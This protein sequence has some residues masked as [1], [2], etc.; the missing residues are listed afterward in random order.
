VEAL[1][2]KA[3]ILLLSL[4]LAACAGQGMQPKATST[5]TG[6][7]SGVVHKYD[8][9]GGIGPLLSISIC[10]GD[11]PPWF[12]GRTLSHFYVGVRE[13]DAIANG[14]STPIIAL[15]SPYVV[16]LLAYQD[17]NMA[18]LGS[19]SIAAANYS[20]L[21]FVFDTASA[22]AIF[23]DGTT[24]PVTF[25]TNNGGGNGAGASTTTATDPNIAGAVDVT[26]PASVGSSDTYGIDFNALE[27]M[28][29]VNNN[30]MKIRAAM[31]ASS[32]TQSGKITGTI[33]NQ[34]GSPVQNVVVAAVGSNG[35]IVNTALTGPYGRFNIHNLGA[36]TYSLVLYNAYTTEAGQQYTAIGQ[37]S[38]ATS[39][40]GPTVTVTGGSATATGNLT[41]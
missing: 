18:S 38:T 7:G 35:A 10:L 9:S 26:V 39:I 25:M 5:S 29:V 31:I 19:G 32:A 30:S 37:S 6:T 11:A 1:F 33:L 13:V 21:R 27:S 3:C 41:D 2:K 40:S 24:L 17:G 8:I 15:S 4:S 20:Q 22:Q 28:A 12:S 16:D 23:S 14:Q 36:G 34:S